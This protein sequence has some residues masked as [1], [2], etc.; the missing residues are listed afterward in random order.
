MHAP[1]S[2]LFGG[3]RR[4]TRCCS[5]PASS[6]PWAKRSTRCS[7]ACQAGSRKQSDC[8]TE[9]FRTSAIHPHPMPG[10]V[11]RSRVGRSLLTMRARILGALTLT[12]LGLGAS[13]VLA[14]AL[15]TLEFAGLVEGAADV[16]AREPSVHLARP[17][18]Q[19]TRS[20]TLRSSTTRSQNPVARPRTARDDAD[21]G[22]NRERSLTSFAGSFPSADAG[23]PKPLARCPRELRLLGSIVNAARPEHSLAAVRVHGGTRLL[24][25]GDR[26]DNLEIV[27][28]RPARAYLRT[29][30]GPPCVLP[31]FLP[32]SERA[33]AA[34]AP[35]PKLARAVRPKKRSLFEPDELRE[36]IR[37]VAPN[38]FAVSRGLLQKALGNVAALRRGGRFRIKSEDGKSRGLEIV[39]MRKGSPLQYLGLQKGDLIRK[40]N[41]LDLT[42]PDGALQAYGI[43]KSQ[44]R[45][46]LAI[47]R[48]GGPQTLTYLLE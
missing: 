22:T 34:P 42:Q 25:V 39:T 36:G 46:T 8:R 26:V 28:L 27:A 5:S 38:T 31:V 11:D 19:V 40:L 44:E 45:F 48:S 18:S 13:S 23:E 10:I 30:R 21:A 2:T 32:A 24:R 16:L 17:S 4:R 20:E 12:V 3:T 33:Q 7:S 47:Q 43:I 29:E 9:K 14:L 6:K 37:T 41:G 15:M 35:A 1:C